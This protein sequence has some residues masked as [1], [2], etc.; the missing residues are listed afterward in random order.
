MSTNAKSIRKKAKRQNSR[1]SGLI[2]IGIIIVAL[3]GWVAWSVFQSS[4]SA[5]TPTGRTGVEVGDLAPDFTVPTLDG[6]EFR[7]SEHQGKPTI[8]FFMAYWCGPCTAEARALG[9]LYQEYEGQLNVIAID[10]DASS[11]PELLSQFKHAANDGAFTWA[12][13]SGFKVASS[14]EVSYLDTTL[15]LDAKGVIVYRDQTPSTYD[16]LKGELEKL[17]Q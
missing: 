7:L 8:I 14:Y 15:I 1:S 13:D 3:A 2:W 10:V 6:G 4:T 17:I 11:T 16:T 9:Q 12:F 5:S